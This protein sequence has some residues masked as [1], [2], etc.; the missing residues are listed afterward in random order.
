M[1]PRES[2]TNARGIRSSVASSSSENRGHSD[3]NE[4]HAPQARH[5]ADQSS[6]T[7]AA[8]MIPVS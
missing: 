5:M 7:S 4:Q 8:I 6:R 1:R 3:E 2:S